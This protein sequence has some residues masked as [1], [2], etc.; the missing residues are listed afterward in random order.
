MLLVYQQKTLLV[1]YAEF[2]Y[3]AGIHKRI[4]FR[5]SLCIQEIS[6]TTSIGRGDFVHLAR[7]SE[8]VSDH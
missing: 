3:L 4:L 6:V 1:A 5:S 2:Y 8:K 7:K